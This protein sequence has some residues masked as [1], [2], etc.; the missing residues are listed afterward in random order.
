MLNITE[1]LPRYT[2]LNVLIT[3]ILDRCS[4]ELEQQIFILDFYNQFN[5]IQAF[6]MML[7]DLV[8]LSEMERSKILLNSLCREIQRF[9]QLV[10]ENK[11][12]FES[13]DIKK[14]YTK[15]ATQYDDQINRQL[16]FTQEAWRE[17]KKVDNSL[18]TI[19]FKEHGQQEEKLLWEEHND[20]KKRY[21]AEKQILSNLYDQ[22]KEAVNRA[23]NY[24]DNK[25]RALLSL[26]Q[27]F[28]DI[29]EK[30]MPKN[31]ATV[32]KGAYFDMALVSA[33][34]KKCNGEQF[35]NISELDLYA[36]LNLLP[37][38]EELIIKNGER[39][40]IYYLIH[41]LYERLPK[42]NNQAWR[43]AILQSLQLDE[44][45]YQSKYRMAKS[46]DTTPELKEFADNLD[47]LFKE[48]ES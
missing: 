12:T 24:L 28:S 32:Q 17:Y 25:F 8:A 5:D 43:T 1:I 29:L 48:F 2:R 11:Q 38:S 37:S 40:R 6:E 20:L 13:I 19:G 21:N 41:K 33:I 39:N 7:I 26:S 30:Y 18:D 36:V 42:E 14:M 47:E 35:E 15:I 4:I 10:S 22:K 46:K 16:F 34:H 3:E 27:K 9:I 45:I 31:K 23:Q 44:R